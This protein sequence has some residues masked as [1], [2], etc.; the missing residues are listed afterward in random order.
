MKKSKKRKTHSLP[1]VPARSAPQRPSTMAMFLLVTLS[2]SQMASSLRP[3]AGL[4]LGTCRPSGYLP[5]RSG[6]CEKSNDPDCCEDGK[7]YPQYRCSPPVT[8][9]TKAVLTLNSFEKGKDGPVRV[10]QRVPQ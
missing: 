6:N 4:G 1:I 2:A 7:M 10:R 9:S 3:H 8:A 5:G